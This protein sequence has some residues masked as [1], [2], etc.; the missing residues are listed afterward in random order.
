M[1]YWSFTSLVL[2]TLMFNPGY[3]YGISRVLAAKM[4]VSAEAGCCPVCKSLLSRVVLVMGMDDKFES[5]ISRVNAGAHCCA[6]LGCF[7]R[8]SVPGTDVILWSRDS[9][10][11]AFRDGCIDT[12]VNKLISAWQRLLLLCSGIH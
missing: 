6:G 3:A 12:N 7:A 11:S 9:R 10:R 2:A 1:F 4:T 5:V 8:R